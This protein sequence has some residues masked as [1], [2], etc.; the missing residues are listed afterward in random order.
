M[1]HK[2][3]DIN[4]VLTCIYEGVRY[5]EEWK[6]VNN[7]EKEYQIS[8]FGRVKSLERYV[9]ARHGKRIVKEKILK[10]NI[11]G[12][13]YLHIRLFKD[14]IGETIKIHHLVS[15]AFHNH[16]HRKRIDIQNDTNH[17]QA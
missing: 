6:P 16:R 1:K 4:K 10:S 17:F 7:Y 8:S 5:F 15:A 11:Y 12:R 9:N 14:C 2:S 13:G 3:L